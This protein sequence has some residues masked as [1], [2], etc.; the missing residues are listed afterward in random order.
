METAY[1]GQ[2]WGTFKRGEVKA[3]DLVLVRWVDGPDSIHLVIEIEQ[4]AWNYKGDIGG[5]M[6]GKDGGVSSFDCLEQ[7]IEVKGSI[8]PLLRGSRELHLE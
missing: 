1:K 6:L 5:E 3:G 8:L 7:I 2:V 4:H